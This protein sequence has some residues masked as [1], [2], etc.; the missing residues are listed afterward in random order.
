MQKLS[1][2]VMW[3]AG[4]CVFCVF[5]SVCR[6]VLMTDTMGYIANLIN[7]VLQV[8]NSKIPCVRVF[9]CFFFF[10]SLPVIVWSNRSLST[11]I[12]PL[13]HFKEPLPIC[14]LQIFYGCAVTQSHLKRKASREQHCFDLWPLV[15]VW[16]WRW[17]TLLRFMMLDCFSKSLSLGEHVYHHSHWNVPRKAAE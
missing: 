6:C 12:E 5:A 3:M 15:S 13:F 11:C 4:A 17:L 16:F 10:N 2:C 14:Y 8:E 7:P 9:F 1:L